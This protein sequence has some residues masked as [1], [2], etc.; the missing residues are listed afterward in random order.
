MSTMI[1]GENLPTG[2]VKYSICTTNYNTFSRLEKGVSSILDQIDASFEVIV[3]DNCSRDGSQELLKVLSG[4]GRIK[5]IE[6]KCSRGKGRQLAFLASKGSYVIDQIDTDDVYKKCLRSL[7]EFYHTYFEGFCMLADGFL[8]APRSLL[9]DVNGWR[10]IQW[11]E[12]RD[13]WARIA[14]KGKLVYIPFECRAWKRPE[15]SGSLSHRVRYQYQRAR[16]LFCLGE[17]PLD[18]AKIGSFLYPAQVAI[19]AAAYVRSKFM[20]KYKQH[21]RGFKKVNCIPKGL[22]LG[23]DGKCEQLIIH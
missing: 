11:G 4:E 13:L 21:M 8:M 19:V 2:E 14:S 22:E 23:P 16:D 5:L 15:G 12:D 6:Q 10:D 1:A 18:E 3:V 7:I 9:V 17:N 20:K